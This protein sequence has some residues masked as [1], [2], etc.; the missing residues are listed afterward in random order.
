MGVLAEPVRGRFGFAIESRQHS[1]GRRGLSLGRGNSS[2]GGQ[3][4][5][6]RFLVRQASAEFIV[7]PG[8]RG[9]DG[10]AAARGGRTVRVPVLRARVLLRGGAVVAARRVS[11]RRG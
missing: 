1:V 8:V 5:L 2:A 10:R 11:G 6:S 4:P 9:A 7:L 3:V